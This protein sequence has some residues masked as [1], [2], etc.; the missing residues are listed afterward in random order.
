MIHLAIHATVR[1]AIGGGE[2]DNTAFFHLAIHSHLLLRVH[3]VEVVV[4]W[5]QTHGKLACIADLVAAWMSFLCCHDNHTSHSSRAIDRCGGTVFQYLERLD[6]V[7]VQSSNG[8]RDKRGGIAWRECVG[9]DLS[10]VFHYHSIDYPQRFG[11]AVDWRCSA[12]AYAWCRTECSADVLYRHTCRL[13]FEGAAD[14][15]H[16]VELHLFSRHLCRGS[17][18][19]SFVHFLHT[20]HYDVVKS[21][22][23]R[24]ED[25]SHAI[26]GFYCL[27][28]HTD[29]A[30]DKFL[31]IWH[32]NGELPVYICYGTCLGS[33]YHYRRSNH[34]F[35][36]ILGKDLSRH[37][38]LRY[39]HGHKKT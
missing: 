7:G 13:S 31:A 26:V 15:S 1:G 27:S 35:A 2:I 18:E 30:D 36:V 20:C 32:F 10:H 17:G 37:F 11:A 16:T 38:R 9:I 12:D 28:H 34:W 6:V 5:F 39:C 25:D 21:L 3:D 19:E 33:F 4:A 29:I 8:R 24:C 22:C 23:V 14:V